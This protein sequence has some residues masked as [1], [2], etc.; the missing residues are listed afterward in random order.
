MDRACCLLDREQ[1]GAY[2]FRV[3]RR[4]CGREL[5]DFSLD[6]A[7]RLKQ[8]SGSAVWFFFFLV[9]WVCG[10]AA[11]GSW[12]CKTGGRGAGAPCVSISPELVD[13]EEQ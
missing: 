11:G 10:A 12:S 13:Y 7:L 1:R 6:L 5:C 4:C 9:V 8:R 3:H 2:F